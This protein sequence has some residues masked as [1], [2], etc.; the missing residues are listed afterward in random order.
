MLSR[1]EYQTILHKMMRKHLTPKFINKIMKD[2]QLYGELLTALMEADWK[3]DL[4]DHG[5]VNKFGFRRN[6]FKWAIGRIKREYSYHKKYK[7]CEFSNFDGIGDSKYEANDINMFLEDFRSAIKTSKVLKPKEKLCLEGAFIQM[8]PLEKI[9]DNSKAS[10]K[11]CINRGLDKLEGG[12]G[13]FK[14]KRISNNC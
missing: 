8:K 6:S 9:R 13:I 7:V 4:D 14:L 10:T 5:H 3:H 2:D 1:F 12:Y 11:E